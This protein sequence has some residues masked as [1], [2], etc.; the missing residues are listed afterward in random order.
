MDLS[1]V[2]PAVI[3]ARGKYA[4]VNG[5]YKRLMSVMQGFAQ[6][7]CDALRHGL[8]ETSNLEWAIERFQN[9]EHLANSLQ[10]YAK[11]VADLKAQKDELYQL[12]WG[13]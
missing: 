9:A 11:T 5:E 8:N 3:E 12:A 6:D 13:K 10:S 1:I 4:T 7:A 2:D